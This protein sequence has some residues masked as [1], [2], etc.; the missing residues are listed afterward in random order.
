MI[1]HITG[2]RDNRKENTDVLGHYSSIILRHGDP[3]IFPNTP[4]WKYLG[5]RCE[6]IKLY[7][8]AKGVNLISKLTSG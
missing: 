4:G 6:V 3:Y 8:L 2:L 7:L 5:L 1:A